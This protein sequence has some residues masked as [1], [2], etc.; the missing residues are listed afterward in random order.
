MIITPSLTP[1]PPGT[2]MAR[3]PKESDWKAFRK[4]VP[5]LRERYLTEKNKEIVAIFMDE[6]RTP[7]EQFWDARERIEKERK[8]LEDCLD[9]HS[10]SSMN[11]Y[12]YLM[13]RHGML[14]DSDLE[15]FSED[16][17]NNIKQILRS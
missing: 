2:K 7:T 10:R 16:L 12:I 9:G 17:K 8:I 6:I 5:E 1:S 4:M 15:N 13:Y 3:K 14:N 11:G